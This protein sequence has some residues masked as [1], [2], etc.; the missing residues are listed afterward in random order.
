M[1]MKKLYGNMFESKGERRST[2]KYIGNRWIFLTPDT[3]LLA[4]G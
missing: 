1:E 2:D 3:S 4:A